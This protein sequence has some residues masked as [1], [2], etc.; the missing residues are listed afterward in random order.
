[1]QAIE[2]ARLRLREMTPGDAPFIL[3]MLNDP[4]W[5]R[6]I[7]D[8]GVRT[9]DGALDYIVKGPMVS[10]AKHGFGLWLVENLDGVPMGMCGLIRRDTLEDVDIGFAFMPP[11]RGKGYACEAAE[12]SLQVAIDHGMTRIVGIVSYHNADS[13]ALLTRLGFVFER[14]IV[15]PKGSEEIAL[16]AKRLP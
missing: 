7:G 3:E 4:D 13:I 5:I 14:P 1:M 9:V 8:R 10:Y 2:T 12:A 6:N 11:F 15:M 16:Y